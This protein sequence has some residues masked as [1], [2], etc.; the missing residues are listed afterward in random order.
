MPRILLYGFGPYDSHETNIS[1]ELVKGIPL[2]PSVQRQVFDVRFDRAMFINAIVRID[3]EIIIGLGQSARSRKIRIERRAV[4]L[5]GER[6]E[7]KRPISRHGHGHLF[8]SLEIPHHDQVRLSYDAGTYV[9]NFSMY[10]IAEHCRDSGRRCGFIHLP[11]RYDMQQAKAF[12]G[13]LVEQTLLSRN[14]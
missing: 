11:K 4:N 13:K 1:G 8:M 2:P 5:M 14:H 10:V 12:V 3:P 7:K 6:G 9:C